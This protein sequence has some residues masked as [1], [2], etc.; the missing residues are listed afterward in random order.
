MTTQKFKILSIDGGGFRGAYSAHILKRIEEEFNINWK[1]DFNLVAGTS[2]GSIIAAGLAF[3]LS[4]KELFDFYEKDGKDIFKKRFLY[5]TGLFASKYHQRLEYYKELFQLND[6]E[7]ILKL[8]E[9][10][11]NSSHRRNSLCPCGSGK[12]LKQCHADILGEIIKI[13]SRQ[14]LIEE[15]KYL[16]AFLQKSRNKFIQNIDHAIC[17]KNSSPCHP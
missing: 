7:S 12:S 13:H 2:T 16:D 3:G 15:Y 6:S 11:I 5:R 8:L 4:A 1:K 14:G 9:L 17:M 10:L